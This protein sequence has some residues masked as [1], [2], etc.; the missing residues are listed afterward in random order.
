MP[1]VDDHDLSSSPA[2]QVE[3]SDDTASDGTSMPKRDGRNAGRYWEALYHFE[4]DF[5]RECREHRGREADA[6]TVYKDAREPRPNTQDTLFIQEIQRVRWRL[7]IEWVKLERF[8]ALKYG[9]LKEKHM[10]DDERLGLLREMMELHSLNSMMVNDY[11]KEL[12]KRMKPGDPA[13]GFA[14]S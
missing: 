1:P 3:A 8:G 5:Q 14:A 10:E 9:Y 12:M 6:G 4:I 11:M 7:M 13:L 2:P